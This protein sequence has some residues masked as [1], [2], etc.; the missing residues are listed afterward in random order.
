MAKPSAFTAAYIESD[1]VKGALSK[2][3]ASFVFGASMVFPPRG[4]PKFTFL[5][6]RGAFCRWRMECMGT[7]LCFT[8]KASAVKIEI[9]EY[10]AIERIF[11]YFI[12]GYFTI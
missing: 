2:V 9:A 12:V 1:S 4:M 8:R 7:V 10:R 3:N 5:L 6:L 11:E